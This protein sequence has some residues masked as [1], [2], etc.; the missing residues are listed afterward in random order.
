MNE[1]KKYQLIALT[2]GTLLSAS[3]Q[4][5][6]PELRHS[7]LQRNSLSEYDLAM[8]ADGSSAAYYAEKA[9]TKA[10]DFLIVLGD[11][12]GCHTYDECVRE[13]RLF[14]EKCKSPRDQTMKMRDGI[15]SKQE[16][17]NPFASFFKIY[18][19]S[20][21]LDEFSG[22]RGPNPGNL[23][24]DMN[25]LKIIDQSGLSQKSFFSGRCISMAGTSFPPCSGIW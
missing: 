17:H 4:A 14:P 16:K 18:L 11:T 10:Q 2:L 3:H 25:K 21:S 22:T 8:C 5:S 24:F 6:N 13:C 23:R 19:P 1:L 7:V 12:K 20:C 15:W 9:T